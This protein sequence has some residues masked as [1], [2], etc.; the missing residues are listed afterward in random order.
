M[1]L[2]TAPP[3][4]LTDLEEHKAAQP[5]NSVWFY[6]GDARKLDQISDCSVD[7][8]VTSPPYWRQRDYGHAD[9]IGQEKTPNDYIENLMACLDEWRRILRPHASIFVNLGDTIRDKALV[10]IP[11]Q[12]MLAAQSRGWLIRQR[13]VWVKSYGMPDPSQ[14]R[15]PRR[16]ETIFQL[17]L[18][19]NPYTDLYG[20]TKKYE[21]Q[22]KSGDV[23]ALRSTR[24][25]TKHLAP[26]P[27]ELV[28]RAI[29]LAAPKKV[30]PC[31]SEPRRRIVKPSSK[32]DMRRPQA[33][34]AVEL[35]NN[36]DLTEEHLS[37]I[38]ATG[39]RDAGKASKMKGGSWNSKRTEELAR[40]AKTVLGGYFREFTFPK[41]IHSGW[42][43]CDCKSALVPGVVLD[44]F[45]GCGTTLRVAARLGYSAI[46]VDLV[47]QS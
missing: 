39:I 46:G 42:S 26:F 19:A 3:H 8:I 12:F 35:F 41:R 29:L 9:Q 24:R 1:H 16:H 28:E 33:R 10:G 20:Y 30:C 7:V 13:I 21:S 18:S 4:T 25:K 31:C 37:A 38:R 15:L 5:G 36:S 23:W 17:S 40:E 45:A 32:L 43:S 6:E 14:S 44:P 34:R 11:E 22:A 2:V 47:V 27:E